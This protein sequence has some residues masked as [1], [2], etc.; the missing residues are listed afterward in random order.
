VLGP[1]RNRRSGLSLHQEWSSAGQAAR[2]S[3]DELRVSRL[4]V[5]RS[6][7]NQ[8]TAGALVQVYS[9]CYQYTFLQW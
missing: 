9:H 4:E 3:N 5:R 2:P 1:L 8:E 6:L 7:Q